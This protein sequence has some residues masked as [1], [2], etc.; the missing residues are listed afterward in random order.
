VTTGSGGSVRSLIVTYFAVQSVGV[1]AFWLLLF[2]VPD[3]RQHFTIRGADFAA[4]GA[5]APPD[6]LIIAAGSAL[7]TLQRGKGWGVHMA[8]LVSGA[9]VYATLYLVTAALAGVMSP[10]GAVIM[11]PPSVASIIASVILT[12]DAHADSLS[13]GA[14]A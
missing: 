5:F 9:V 1:V 6:L 4:L 2:A 8:W 12:R 13:P 7:V 3:L 14:G 11:T 10:V